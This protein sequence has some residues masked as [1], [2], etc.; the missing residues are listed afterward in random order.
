M[1]RTRSTRTGRAIPFIKL[2]D[3][4]NG[5][6]EICDEAID[7]LEEYDTPIGVVSIV[8]KYRTGKSLF[9]N[10]CLLQSPGFHVGSTVHAC[11]KGLWIYET[12]VKNGKKCPVFVMDTEGLG[13]LDADSTH[14]VRIFAMALLLSSFFIY[15]SLNAIDENAVQNLSLVVNVCKQIRLSADREATPEEL[16]REVFPPLLWIVRDFTLQLVDEN[17]D[18]MGPED[19]LRMALQDTGNEDKNTVRK[20]LRACFPDRTCAT[21]IRPANDEAELQKL[22]HPKA[23]LKPLF[24]QQLTYIRDYIFSRVQPKKAANIPITGRALVAYAR[25]IVESI[26]KG[27]APVIRDSWS[28]IAEIQCRDAYEAALGAYHSALQPMK[29]VLETKPTEASIVQIWKQA[30]AAGLELFRERAVSSEYREQWIEKLRTFMQQDKSR[31]MDELR[32]LSESA[33]T[34]KIAE[35]DSAFLVDSEKGHVIQADTLDRLEREMMEIVSGII[36]GGGGGGAGDM[37]ICCAARM[38]LDRFHR[39][40]WCWMRRL[41]E[42]AKRMETSLQK[43]TEERESWMRKLEE[44]R[45]QQREQASQEREK[46]TEMQQRLSELND[47]LTQNLADQE[48]E[49]ENLRETRQ[50]HEQEV[51]SLKAKLAEAEQELVSREYRQ[52]ADDTSA[53]V[54]S[55][56]EQKLQEITQERD[57]LR[58]REISAQE[59]FLDQIRSMRKECDESIESAKKSYQQNLREFQDQCRRDVEKIQSQLQSLRSTVQE[60]ETQLELARERART[61]EEQN[62]NVVQMTQRMME[63]SKQQWEQDSMQRNQ[64][65]STLHETRL[66][67]QLEWSGKIRESEKRAAKATAQVEEYKRKVS[68]CVA[69]HEPELKRFRSENMRMKHENAKLT[70]D[71]SWSEKELQTKTQ[72]LTQVQAKYEKLLNEFHE[73]QRSKE[74]DMLKV[75]MQYEKQLATKRE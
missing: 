7:I 20:T 43:Y 53:E 45:Q 61:L 74:L 18:R 49:L 1:A 46:Y 55:E 8:G 26:N 13:A 30:Y 36:G 12:P 65:L 5:R 70:T 60:R 39:K 27:S 69:E 48:A 73:L 59:S 6:Y 56:Y 10:K 71:K 9:L 68:Q 2:V 33:I 64:E 51:V 19:Y 75:T 25:S 11:T 31:L 72:L 23:T 50:E 32:R 44:D 3:A 21:L 4:S 14:D 29:E 28:M 66:K 41:A 35:I 22:D 34:G 54:S 24:A 57:L 38:I 40:S 16:G 63:T 67:E 62:K 52:D 17:G 42:T 58:K 47:T 15:N 37:N